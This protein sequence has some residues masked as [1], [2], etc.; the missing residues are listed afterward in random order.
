VYEVF[1]GET[2]RINTRPDGAPLDDYLRR[3]GRFRTVAPALDDL[4]AQVERD[5]KRLDELARVFPATQTA[6]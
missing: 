2:Y 1:D 6:G 4:R 5:W 3:Q